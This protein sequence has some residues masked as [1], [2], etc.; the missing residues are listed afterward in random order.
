MCF[1]DVMPFYRCQ[2]WREKRDS[3]DLRRGNVV[4]GGN[5][6]VYIYFITAT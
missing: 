4:G 2:R 1:V 6:V 5:N 3:L